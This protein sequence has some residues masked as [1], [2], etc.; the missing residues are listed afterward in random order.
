MFNPVTQAEK[1]D[2]QARYVLVNQT[3]ATRCGFRDK[4][5]LLGRTA[6]EVFIPL[7]VGGGVRSVGD[8]RALLLAGVPED[9]ALRLAA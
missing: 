8:A 4:G 9:T 6:E 2:P 1:F 3:L 5:E 7:T